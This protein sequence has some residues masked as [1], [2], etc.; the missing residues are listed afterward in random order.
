MHELGL[1]IRNI[2]YSMASLYSCRLCAI[3]FCLADCELQNSA[4]DQSCIKLSV[5]TR[6]KHK[7]EILILHQIKLFSD[8]KLVVN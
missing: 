4:N 5:C 7:V 3:I 6:Q 8:R 2:L 1:L